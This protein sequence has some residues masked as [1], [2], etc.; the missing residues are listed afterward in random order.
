MSDGQG[1]TILQDDRRS[2]ANDSAIDHELA[3]EELLA[4]NDKIISEASAFEEQYS[5]SESDV[6]SPIT[7]VVSS[8]FYLIACPNPE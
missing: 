2:A 3:A 1:D 8:L 7:T 6:K 4:A 5:V